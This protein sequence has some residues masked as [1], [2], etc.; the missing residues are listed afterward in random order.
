MCND[1][2]RLEAYRCYMFQGVELVLCGYNTTARAPHLNGAHPELTS[3]EAAKAEA[4]FHNRLSLQAGS[5]QTLAGALMWQNVR[6]KIHN[7]LLFRGL[8][9]WI[10]MERS[11]YKPERGAVNA[12]SR[13]STLN[14]VREGRSTCLHP[15]RHRG[16]DC[17]ADRI[18]VLELLD[19][20][21]G[22]RISYS[23]RVTA[24][25]QHVE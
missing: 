8:V 24:L 7:S 11:W 20:A 16:Q 4:L 13:R 19:K 1:R 9:S 21:C 6:W 5:Y 23:R 15:G 25:R 14:C 3:P 17:G 10:R 12:C 2:C 18:Q 22:S